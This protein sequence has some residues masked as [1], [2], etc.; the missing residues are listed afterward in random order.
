MQ[1]G[2]SNAAAMARI[3]AL[4]IEE[5]QSI[6]VTSELAR[7]WATFY[8]NEALRVPG[9][10]SARGRALLMHQAAVLLGDDQ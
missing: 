4:T 9:N 5:L 8:A 6:E 3:N 1:W 7:Q 10:P 2:S